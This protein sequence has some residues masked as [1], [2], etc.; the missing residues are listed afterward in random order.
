M[1]ITDLKPNEM[2]REDAK[3]IASEYVAAHA[4][5]VQA[6]KDMITYPTTDDV[7]NKEELLSAIYRPVVKAGTN[8][9]KDNEKKLAD[10]CTVLNDFAF[11]QV[12]SNHGSLTNLQNSL[13]SVENETQHPSK[14]QIDPIDGRPIKTGKRGTKKTTGTTGSQPASDGTRANATIPPDTSTSETIGVPVVS[15][16]P[17]SQ[18][19]FND[20]ITVGTVPTVIPPPTTPPKLEVDAN[21]FCCGLWHQI[22]TG[23]PSAW[24]PPLPGSI[25]VCG[26]QGVL[27]SLIN[28][29]GTF[30]DQYGNV[31]T[32][33]YN[34]PGCGDTSTTPPPNDIPPIESLPPE[35][36]PPP[37]DD[38]PPGMVYR[39]NPQTG[40]MECI[41]KPPQ[42]KPL[43]PPDICKSL[44]LNLNVSCDDL[45]KEMQD[46][47]KNC[48]FNICNTDSTPV[49]G[50]VD[51]P[52]PLWSEIALI[53]DWDNGTPISQ[54]P[55]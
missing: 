7:L 54:S 47:L 37:A 31:W 42:P 34:V 14:T 24:K 19:T 18:Q 52:F 45:P 4:D 15:L 16:P 41:P 32:I 5:N 39:L 29:V 38:C 1:D 49:E 44:Q 25:F 20:H 21:L 11:G 26:S 9:T 3:A 36:T 40:N 43:P 30:H 23:P 27:D 6:F 8:A 46:K 35:I 13:S 53:W 51:T 17:I 33:P 28:G 48:G 22:T 50:L 12:S 55:V 10:I 2:N